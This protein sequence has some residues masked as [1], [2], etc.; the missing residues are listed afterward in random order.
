MVV[1]TAGAAMGG[2]DT[3]VIVVVTGGAAGMVV[4]GGELSVAGAG[5]RAAATGMSSSTGAEMVFGPTT[6]RLW[7]LGGPA[8]STTRTRNAPGT[9]C[10]LV[11]IIGTKRLVFQVVVWDEGP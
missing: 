11:P 7:T 10:G 3:V 1:V 4:E 6:I 8:Q 9:W 5:E 2:G